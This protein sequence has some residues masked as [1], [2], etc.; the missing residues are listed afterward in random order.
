VNQ[1][2]KP[3]GRSRRAKSS[4]A[5]NAAQTKPSSMPSGLP[6][7]RLLTGADDAAFDGT[8]IIVAQALVWP[9]VLEP[10]SRPRGKRSATQAGR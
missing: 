9:W 8:R 1:V 5:G 10:V 3:I 7:Y 2:S 4:K 6:I